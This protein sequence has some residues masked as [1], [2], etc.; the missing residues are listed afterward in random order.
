VSSARS[1]PRGFK[2]DNRENQVGS[3][4]ESVEKNR[5][6]FGSRAMNERLGDWCEVVA[7]LGSSQLKH[8]KQLEGS[9]RSERT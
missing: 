4:R 3:V 9:R 7:S 5:C 2:E 6:S 1:V 8:L